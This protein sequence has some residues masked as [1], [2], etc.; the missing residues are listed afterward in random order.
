M[1]DGNRTCRFGAWVLSH[2]AHRI[3]DRLEIELAISSAGV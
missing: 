1:A 3:L 2:S